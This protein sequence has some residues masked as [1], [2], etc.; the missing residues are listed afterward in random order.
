MADT[1]S[2]LLVIDVQRGLFEKSA[3]IYHAEQLLVTIN[4]LIERARAAGAPV[5]FVRHASKV[6]PYR[7]TA[8]E[9]HPEL[10]HSPKDL[11]TDKQH[12]NAFEKT[13]LREELERL[14]ARRL[15][16]TG[17]TTHGCVR[18]TCLGALA[19]GYEVVIASDGHSSYH[20]DAASLCEEWNGR[21]SVAGAT[22]APAADI[23][24]TPLRERRSMAA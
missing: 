10:R 1:R 14:G 13:A 9:L 16:I 19:L 5:I 20:R 15:V 21:L 17:L 7:S 24:F 6:L 2:A 12:G 18:A 8:W 4:S 23:G 3:P 22:V 11:L